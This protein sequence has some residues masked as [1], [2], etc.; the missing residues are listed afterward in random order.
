LRLLLLST[1][2]LGEGLFGFCL[3]LSFW[4]LSLKLRF[5]EISSLK[6]SAFCMTHN[7]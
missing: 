1:W 4:T 3:R 5:F 7:G 6:L 2:R